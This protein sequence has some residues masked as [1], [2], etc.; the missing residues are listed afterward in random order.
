SMTSLTQMAYGSRLRRQGRSRPCLA[1]QASSRR[2]ARRR[3]AGPSGVGGGAAPPTGC[4]MFK[5][6]TL[7]RGTGVPLR[8]GPLLEPCPHCNKKGVGRPARGGP[9]PFGVVG[10]MP[11]PRSTTLT[12]GVLF[13]D[14]GG[15]RG[16]VARRL[17]LLGRILLVGRL[18]LAL[19]RLLLG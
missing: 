17:L 19:G 9:D 16:G 8:S 5:G 3:S 7:L 13:Q 14:R 6:I 1:N 12:A 15:R 18:G 2:A 11:V 10:A 4:W